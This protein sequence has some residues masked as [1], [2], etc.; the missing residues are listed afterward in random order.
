MEVGGETDSTLLLFANR[1]KLAA[2]PR[3]DL[4]CWASAVA[5]L[6][7]SGQK[8]IGDIKSLVT[9][10]YAD[11]LAETR[12]L[13]KTDGE[14]NVAYREMALA[15]GI[16]ENPVLALSQLVFV[17]GRL[18]NARKLLDHAAGNLEVRGGISEISDR[19]EDTRRAL[20]DLIKENERVVLDHENEE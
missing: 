9:G 7:H 15:L 2:E 4:R 3:D 5:D 1:A 12:T 16:A 17:N 19:L 14:V 10:A 11:L 13:A 6:A 8:S 18:D 20:E